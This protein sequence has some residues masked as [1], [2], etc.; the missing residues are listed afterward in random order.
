MCLNNLTESTQLLY[1]N[2]FIYCFKCVSTCDGLA[3]K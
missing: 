3:S 1:S 2:C